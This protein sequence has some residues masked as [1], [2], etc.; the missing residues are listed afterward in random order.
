MTVKST[1]AIGIIQGGKLVSEGSWKA[2]LETTPFI[3]GAIQ[4]PSIAKVAQLW[5]IAKVCI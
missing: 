1:P 3:G 5:V 2:K 4:S